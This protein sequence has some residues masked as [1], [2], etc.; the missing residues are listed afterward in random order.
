MNLSE[1]Y[2]LTPALCALI[3]CEHSSL[4]IQVYLT[5]FLSIDVKMENCQSTSQRILLL[6]GS[7]ADQASGTNLTKKI[8]QQSLQ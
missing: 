2:I 1:L 3:P 7:S 4:F 6:N 5:L 8:G